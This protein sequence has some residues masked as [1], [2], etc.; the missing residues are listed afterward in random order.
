MAFINKRLLSRKTKTVLKALSVLILCNILVIWYMGFHA[1]HKQVLLKEGE[2]HLKERTVVDI[3]IYKLNETGPPIYMGKDFS[4]FIH[5][6]NANYKR[7]FSYSAS[8]KVSGAK[9]VDIKND[10]YP[11]VDFKFVLPD[12]APTINI[13]QSYAMIV[14]VNSGAKGNK[15]RKRREAIRQTWGNQSNCEQRKA[16]QDERLKHLRWLLV[17]VVG[18]AGSRT[19]DDELNIAEAR[20]HN[21]MLIGN[22]TDNYINNVIKFYMGQVWASRFDVK[23]TMKT[24][25]DVYVRIP[26]VLEYLVHAKFPRP[27]YG[28]ATYPSI[29]VDRSIG[30]KWAVSWKYYNKTHF[31]RFNPGAFFILSSDLLNRLWNYTCVRKPFHTDDAYVGVAM[32]DFKVNITKMHSFRAIPRMPQF[33]RSVKDC[34]MMNCTAF[35]DA[36]DPQSARQ[37]HRRLQSHSCSNITMKC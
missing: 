2:I 35:G 36:V 14:L 22:I 6:M 29:R 24:D 13:S 30:G 19:N 4:E 12:V 34:E 8:D 15:F 37:L 1:A 21:D 9:N 27:F 16:S 31:P 25:D 32:Q 10:Y 3:E 5:R 20:Q 33:I 17:F 7:A 23:Y 11:F 28:G 18:K 26:R